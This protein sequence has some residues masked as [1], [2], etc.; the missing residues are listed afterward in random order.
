[1]TQWPKTVYLSS[2]VKS[3][4][5]KSSYCLS[6]GDNNSFTSKYIPL[7]FIFVSVSLSVMAFLVILRGGLAWS[8]MGIQWRT[9]AYTLRGIDIYTLRGSENFIVELGRIEAGFHASPWGCLL[10]NVFYGG[11][12]P[13]AA[14]KVYFIAANILVLFLASYI[15]YRKTK[16][17]SCRLGI[18]TL[19]TSI[20]SI[21]FLKAIDQG[22]AGGMICAFLLIAWAIC[23]EH[24]YISGILIGLAMVKP[25]DALIVCL[26]MLFANAV[27]CWCDCGCISL[28]CSIHYDQQRNDRAASRFL[29]R[30]EQS[31]TWAVC[32]NIYPCLQ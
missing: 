9:C 6:T 18:F 28:A 27:D 13:F 19:I 11:F 14:A 2:Q 31:R 20:L 32:G 16:S 24:E 8:D 1:M 22:N 12:L 23:D 4:Q 5:V 10:E 21:D 3:S 17:I 25:Q 29:A 7:V 15:L 26:M 30:A